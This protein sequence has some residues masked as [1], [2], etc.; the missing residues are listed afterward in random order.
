MSPIWTKYIA[1]LLVL[2]GLAGCNSGSEK[3]QN[4]EQITD[5]EGNTYTTI[6]IGDQVWM[7]ENL[8]TSTFSDGTPIQKVEDYEEWANLT[9]PAY[10]WYNNDS[11][12]SDDFGALYNCYTIETEKLCPDGWHVPTDEDWIELETALGG[13][14]IAGGAMKESG[15]AHWKTPNTLA[16]NESGFTALPGGY[17]SYNGTFNL[18]R[19]ESYWWS[20]SEKN[21]YGLTNTV[22][23]RNL[24]YD[25]QILIRLVA[26]K[27]NGFSVRCVK[28]PQQQ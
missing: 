13:A 1:L 10:C 7:A 9:L 2:T 11:L 20:T 18:M 28:N 27:A 4:K 19:I 22:I 25:D 24:K 12:N 14:G 17:R 5:I 21:W 6:T 16:S 8:K 3:S 23:Y 26:E 15:T